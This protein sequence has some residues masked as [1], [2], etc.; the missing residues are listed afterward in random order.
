MKDLQVDGS[1]NKEVT[2]GKKWVAYYKV[3]PFYRMLY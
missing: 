1:W 3:T 2:L